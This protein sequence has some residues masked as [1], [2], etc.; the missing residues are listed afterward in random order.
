M[1]LL[2]V[3]GTVVTFFTLYLQNNYGWMD[4]G[5]PSIVLRLRRPWPVGCDE[6]STRFVLYSNGGYGG[7][8]LP[9]Q[10]GA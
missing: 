6:L 1:H 7:K 10:F 3:G 4:S 5:M 9:D 8:C 2:G